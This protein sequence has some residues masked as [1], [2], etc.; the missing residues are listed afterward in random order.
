MNILLTLLI[1]QSNPGAVLDSQVQNLQASDL[2]LSSSVSSV[3]DQITSLTQELAELRAQLESVVTSTVVSGVFDASRWIPPDG[4]LADAIHAIQKHPDCG[5]LD[6][7]FGKTGCRIEIPRGVYYT[8]T[9]HL[10]RMVHIVGTGGRGWGASTRIITDGETAIHVAGRL[11]CQ[12]EMGYPVVRGGRAADGSWSLIEH[13]WL[14]DMEGYWHEDHRPDP[15]YSAGVHAEARV[16]LRDMWI[17]EFTQGIRVSAD[18]NRSSTN[19]DPSVGWVIDENTNA[20]LVTVQDVQV[21]SSRH[22]GVFFDGGDSNAG[23]TIGL[24]SSGNCRDGDFYESLGWPDCANIHDSSF[25]GNTHIAIHTAY[26]RDLRGNWHDQIYSDNPNSRNVWVGTYAEWKNGD[27][28]ASGNDVVL[29]GIARWSSEGNGLRITDSYISGFCSWDDR[30]GRRPFGESLCVGTRAGTGLIS[31][32]AT[33]PPFS[34]VETL[35]IK[36]DDDGGIPRWRLDIANLGSRGIFQMTGTS[37]GAHR[38]G[39][40]WNAGRVALRDCPPDA[41]ILAKQVDV[42]PAEPA[43]GVA[44]TDTD[45]GYFSTPEGIVMCERN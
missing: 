32:D 29:G 36:P 37:T 44:L 4:D 20:N 33:L 23:Y 41:Q 43:N 40:V 7:G 28:I 1:T 14:R 21:S 8:K 42:N 24:D 6:R 13:V 11:F 9:I 39:D 2:V 10:C 12:R 30:E 31:F 38:R 18:V 17:S 34:G 45:V 26:T 15:I 22:S 27:S 3:Q 5:P 35:R 25:L 16:A 19:Y